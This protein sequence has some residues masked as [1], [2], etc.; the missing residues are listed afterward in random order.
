[1]RVPRPKRKGA[2]TCRGCL[3]WRVLAQP[4][5]GPRLLVAGQD[6]CEVGRR[7]A[8]ECFLPGRNSETGLS[9][10]QAGSCLSSPSEAPVAAAWLLAALAALLGE[11]SSP[12]W[13]RDT[14]RSPG[15]ESSVV[16]AIF[17]PCALPST[18]FRFGEWCFRPPSPTGIA[19]LESHNVGPDSIKTLPIYNSGE[20]QAL[21]KGLNIALGSSVLKF[22]ESP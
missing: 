8:A 3:W 22:T 10:L 18:A 9:Q 5:L 4:S 11:S 12:P 1:M 7:E 15:R 16:F 20:S 14:R 19:L 2:G 21:K 6:T 13:R 17:L